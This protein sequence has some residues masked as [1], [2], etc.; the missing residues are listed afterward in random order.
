MVRP[1]SQRAHTMEIHQLSIMQK[2]T[3]HDAT[4]PQLTTTQ[5]ATTHHYDLASKKLSI[6]TPSIALN[7]GW[8]KG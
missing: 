6:I 2:S 1:S 3:D 4:A 5:R 7:H 8:S